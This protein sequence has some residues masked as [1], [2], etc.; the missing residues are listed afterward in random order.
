LIALAAPERDEAPVYI[1]KTTKTGIAFRAEGSATSRKYLLETMVGGVGVLDFDGD[2]RLDIYFVNGA[3]LA[4]PMRP[5]SQPDKSEERFWNRLYRNVGDGTFTDVTASAGVRG[6]SFGMGVAVGDYDNDGRP[7]MYVT[8]YG[9]NILY[10]NDGAGKFSDVTTSAGV[11]GGGWSASA[12]FV[13]VDNDGLLDLFVARYLDWDFRDLWCG[14]K[15]PGARAYCHPNHFEPVSHLLYKNRGDGTFA[16]ISKAA[17]ISAS[18]GKGLGVAIHDYD[19]DGLVDILVANDSF[20]QQLFRNLGGGRFE[21]VGL[22]AGL[23]YDDDGQM[24]AGMGVDFSDYDN[25]G[26]PDAFINALG[27]QRYALFHN[28][29]TNFEYVSGPTGVARATMLHSGWGA[30]FLDYDNDGWKDLFVAQG[31]VMDN[32]E[33]TQPAL[34]YLEPMLLLKNH[35]G[36]FVD[37]SARSGEPFKTPRAARGAAVA[38]LNND[39]HPDLVVSCLGQGAVVLENAGSGRHWIVIHPVGTQSNRDAIGA[40]VRVVSHSGREQHGMVSTA[41]SYLASSDKR[42]H[43]GLGDDKVVK[44]LQVTWPNGAVRT[45]T[46][47]KADQIITI[48]EPTERTSTLDHLVR[49]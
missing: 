45:M 40:R 4:D 13:D 30:R 1:D 34:R 8:N 14:D 26:W 31:H 41:G 15:K 38:D 49:R 29:K 16:D 47:V 17:G 25:D 5:S 46:D 37:V 12:T 24:F 6:H 9:R 2:G 20:P 36:R 11:G 28:R 33:M 10:H 48:Q 35:Q 42:V 7:D 39:G 22:T 44:L 19:R 43:F 3:K 21:E 27:N 23:A 32:I 18:P